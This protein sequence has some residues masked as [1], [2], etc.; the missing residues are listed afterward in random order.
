MEIG[1]S[2]PSY[3]E[4]MAPRTDDIARKLQSLGL[5]CRVGHAP[6]IDVDL[7]SLDETHRQ[8][9]PAPEREKE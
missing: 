7:G 5:T 8:A 1:C 4:A 6:C 9:P 2:D 3:V